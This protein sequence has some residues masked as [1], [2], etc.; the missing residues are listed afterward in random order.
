ML[1]FPQILKKT[2]DTHSVPAPRKEGR[3]GRE[4]GGTEAGNEH[5]VIKG[6]E[7]RS[8]QRG[9]EGCFLSEPRVAAEVFGL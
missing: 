7:K 1:Q 8:R 5:K 6:K 4:G 2:A 9:Q 3:E